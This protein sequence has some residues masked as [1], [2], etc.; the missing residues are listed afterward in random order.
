MDSLVSER[1]ITDPELAILAKAYYEGKGL[2]KSSRAGIRG[3][4]G[5]P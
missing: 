1:W 5:S 2:E 4:A 3:N